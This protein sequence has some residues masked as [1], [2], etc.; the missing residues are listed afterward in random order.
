[1][2]ASDSVLYLSKKKKEAY[3]MDHQDK[4]D[5]AALDAGRV[6]KCI[7]ENEKKQVVEWVRSWYMKAGYKRLCKI[8][9]GKQ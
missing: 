7:P 6:W 4:M 8:M 9:L 2:K 5:A 1:M 3:T